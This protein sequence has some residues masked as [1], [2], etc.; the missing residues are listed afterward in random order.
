M[1]RAIESERAALTSLSGELAFFG[2]LVALIAGIRTVDAARR[3]AP[4][5]IDFDELPSGA[6]Q[7]FE[8]TH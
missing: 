4:L 8:L 7:R 2:A 6:T 1:A 3:Q 5:L